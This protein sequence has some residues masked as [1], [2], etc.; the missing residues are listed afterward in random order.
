MLFYNFI[1][2]IASLFLYRMRPT[3]V[4]LTHASA[5]KKSFFFIIVF[6]KWCFIKVEFVLNGVGGSEM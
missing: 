6:Y 3:Y 5:L 1:K 4:L 2:K